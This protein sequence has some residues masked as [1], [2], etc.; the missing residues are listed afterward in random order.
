MP[1]SKR[2]RGIK[3]KSLRYPEGRGDRKKELKTHLNIWGSTHC[4]CVL[5]AGGNQLRNQQFRLNWAWISLEKELYIVDEE[6]KFLEV[7]LRRRGYLGETS[8]VS[9]RMLCFFNVLLLLF[10]VDIQHFVI[11]FLKASE[12]FFSFTKL[13]T[14]KTQTEKQTKTTLL[15]SKHFDGQPHH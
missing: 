14:S 4:L 11:N 6:V 2:R 8:F 1:S 5:F 3:I 10:F 7:V 12:M 9:K 13:K 15:W